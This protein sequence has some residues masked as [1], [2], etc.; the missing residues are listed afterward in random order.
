M[1][2]L[3]AL[4][5]GAC[6]WQWQYEPQPPTT[7]EQVCEV[8]ER[9]GHAS[10]DNVEPPE[11]VVTYLIP[12]LA[13]GLHGVTIY[14]ENRIFINPQSI[15]PVDDI[16]FHELIHWVL[17]KGNIYPPGRCDSEALARKYTESERGIEQ[18][19]WRLGYGCL[20]PTIFGM[21]GI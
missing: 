2:A 13:E 6:T 5:I 3:I 10:C 12:W 14:E 21:Q 19:D 11:V 16:L 20:D 9:D 15:Y 17:R 4:S 8:L 1:G 18:G 7:F